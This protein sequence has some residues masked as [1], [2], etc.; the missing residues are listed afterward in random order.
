MT[1][2]KLSTLVL[3]SFVGIMLLASCGPNKKERTLPDLE[4]QQQ[5]LNQQAKDDQLL[6]NNLTTDAGNLDKE[7]NAD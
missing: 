4:Q 2:K 1:I 3:T 7:S 5:Q 6:A